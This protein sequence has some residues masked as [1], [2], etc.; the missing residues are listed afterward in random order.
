VKIVSYFNTAMENAKGDERYKLNNE[1]IDSVAAFIE[2]FEFGFTTSRFAPSDYQ[3]GGQAYEEWFSNF[4]SEAR[5]LAGRF[6]LRHR[7]GDQQSAV[8]SIANLSEDK[9]E[10]IRSLLTRIRKVIP[11]LDIGETKKNAIYQKL[12]SLELELDQTETR[13]E[14]AIA[15][16]VDVS[17][18][19][20]DSAEKLDPL[21]KMVE[22]L[23]NVFVRAKSSESALS[24][25]NEKRIALPS[26]KKFDKNMKDNNNDDKIPF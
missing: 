23:V 5:R 7:K 3:D 11:H 13:W 14:N 22:R 6:A 24:I 8:M 12:S 9:K 18:A 1:F 26:P 19:V 2:E 20:G 4:R 16:M 10:E 21:V 17:G 15:I 25:S